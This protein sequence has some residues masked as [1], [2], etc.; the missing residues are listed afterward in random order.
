LDWLVKQFI[1]EG[2]SLKKLHRRILLS[3]AYRQS[4]RFDQSAAEVDAENR[5]LWRFTPRRLEGEIVRDAMLAVSGKLNP[6]VGGPSF[7]PFTTTRFNTTFYH[8]F[9]KDEPKYNRRSVYRMGIITGRDAMLDAFDCPSPSVMAPQRPTTTTPQQALALMN[10]SFVIRQAD[11]FALRVS[12]TA[13]TN[14]QRICMA[15]RMALGRLPDALELKEA[16]SLTGTTSL[17]NLCWV[18]LNSSEFLYVQ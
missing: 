5:L 14:E 16:T 1:E 6:E 11:A 10:H 12:E 4:S 3:A 18:L 13:Q 2:W 8:L 7:Q 17:Q 9:D 15:Y